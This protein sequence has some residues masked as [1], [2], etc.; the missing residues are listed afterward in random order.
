MGKYSRSIISPFSGRVVEFVSNMVC[1]DTALV[2]DCAS[3]AILRISMNTAHRSCIH[4]KVARAAAFQLSNSL[5]KLVKN[6][7]SVSH[8][9]YAELSTCGCTKTA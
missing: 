4:R 3:K 6:L 8:F 1:V 2:A 9:C 7:L 5:P